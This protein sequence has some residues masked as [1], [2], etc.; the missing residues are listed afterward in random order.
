MLNRCVVHIGLHKTGTTT[1]QH[2]LYA[3]RVELEGKYRIHYPQLCKNHNKVFHSL[4]CD[5]PEK[6][7]VNVRRN[8]NTAEKA[9]R[10]NR[11]LMTRLEAE[12]EESVAETLLVSGEDLSSLSRAG[13]RRFKAWTDRQSLEP[14]VICCIRH[15]RATA[16][17]LAQE[18]LKG[19][20]TLAQ[21][22]DNPPVPNYRE[23]LTPWLETFG[24]KVLT[25]YDFEEAR[26][27]ADGI[28]GYFCDIVGLPREFH[29]AGRVEKRN[30]SMSAEAA[31][32]LSALNAE[33]PL[34]V[35]NALGSCR[36]SGDTRAFA[37]IPGRRFRLG[38]ET[39][40][41]VMEAARPQLRW[42][43]DTF[44]LTLKEPRITPDS[45][46]VSIAG[47]A[48]THIA[49]L[50]SDRENQRKHDSLLAKG[51]ARY[52]SR[53][54]AGA[55]IE[56]RE[57]LRIVPGS[58]P[59]VCELAECLWRAG[60]REDA[61]AEVEEGLRLNPGDRRLKKASNRLTRNPRHKNAATPKKSAQRESARSRGATDTVIRW[62][63]H[64]V[65]ARLRMRVP[66]R[67]RRMV[68]ERL[69]G[70]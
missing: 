46:E 68:R 44:G 5:A 38:E 16:A 25:I 18:H 7:H 56:L 43:R 62:Y 12:M 4:F 52:R 10:Y 50:I 70:P 6:Y 19:G 20:W 58:S 41:R 49:L 32:L 1:L 59:A 34:F 27:H 57:A 3:R 13:V 14:R 60:S 35:N 29:V 45:E 15:P 31:V 67:F 23:R 47:P 66:R 37:T 30:E 65:P 61:L 55:E 42:L 22:R 51:R 33:R 28:F 64:F 11:E 48:V 54:F 36:Y 69:I 9:A 39:M 21:I 17:S 26:A 40:G 2:A 53:D 8:I 63:R 24:A